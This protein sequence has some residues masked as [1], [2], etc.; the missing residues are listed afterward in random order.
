MSAP[1]PE[2]PVPGRAAKLISCILP[3]DGTER[4][5]L[6]WLRDQ[7]G[8]IRANSVYCRGHSILQETSARRGKLPEPTLVRVVMIVV[9]ADRADALCDLIYEQA[10]IHRPGGGALMMTPLTFA[11]PFLLP[12]GVANEIGE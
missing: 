5:L 4:R 1:T 3:D 11:M 12:E 8:I 6:G 2:A 9:D 7:Q 10:D